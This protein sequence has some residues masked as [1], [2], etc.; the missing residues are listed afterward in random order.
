M[1]LINHE[2]NLI[3]AWC[4]NFVIVYTVAANQGATFAITEAKLYVPV[5]TLSIR[6]KA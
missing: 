5:A 4:A 1:P 3:L 2:V 6:D